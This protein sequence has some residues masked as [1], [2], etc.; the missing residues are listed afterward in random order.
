VNSA[1]DTFAYVAEHSDHTFK[2]TL[3]CATDNALCSDPIPCGPD[4]ADLVYDIF[5]DG[6]PLNWQ[7]CLSTS[8][9]SKINGL[10]P[11]F[12]E[13][14]FKRLSW[15]GSK[16]VVQP[17]RGR[18]LVNFATN[19]YTTNDHPTTMVVT[20]LGQR[21]SI[22]ATPVEYSWHFGAGS[23]TSTSDPGAPYP[24]L[25]IT[26]RY[27]RVG[28]I[29]PS[30]DTTYRGRYRVGGGAWHAIPDTL[31]VAGRPVRLEVVSATPHLVGY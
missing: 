31:T 21:V 29:A 27:T 17:P 22:E 20:L 3:A 12:V 23:S 26:H 10:T 15:P 18:T 7:A 24:K 8:D 6:K 2:V 9:A 25:R 4:D 30:V 16:L 1:P 11:G 14:A 28:T 5:E 13:R 19:F